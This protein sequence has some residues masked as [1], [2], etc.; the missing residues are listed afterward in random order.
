MKRAL[1]EVSHAGALVT[2]SLGVWPPKAASFVTESKIGRG[3]GRCARPELAPNPSVNYSRED[4]F[5]SEENYLL[6]QQTLP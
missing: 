4:A 2:Y 1:T 5:G 3:Q 6:I